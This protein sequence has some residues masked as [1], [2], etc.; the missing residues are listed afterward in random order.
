MSDRI[1]VALVNDYE[2]VLRGLA[3]MLAPFADRIDVVQLDARRRVTV[4]VDVALY[5]TFA[6]PEPDDEDI[7]R[8]ASNP[9]IRTVAVFTWKMDQDLIDAAVARGATGYFAK[10]STAEHLAEGLQRVAA[11]ERVLE[12]PRRRVPSGPGVRWPGR[13]EGISDRQS[14]ILA[15]IT[16]G[17]RNTE[18][19]ELTHLSPNTVKTHIRTL[20]SKIGAEN[21]VDAVLWGTENGFRP[22]HR[23]TDR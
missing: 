22:D 1:R 10:S 21:R 12:S 8:L 15:L 23:S 9:R 6:Q 20:Y 17:K 16:Q 13:A 19:A 5:D 11:G 2:L 18:I 3:D 4:D 14:E 7:D